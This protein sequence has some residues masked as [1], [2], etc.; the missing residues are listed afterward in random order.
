[1]E[2]IQEF[3]QNY[4]LYEIVLALGKAILVLVIGFPIRNFL[5][6]ALNRVMIK[7]EIDESLRPFLKSLFKSTLTVLILITAASFV[8][9]E[10][11]SFVAILGAAGLAI[12]LALQGTLQNFAGG[13]IILV[14]RPFKVGDYVEAA[15]QAGTVREIQ[16]FN[17]ILTTPDN[18]RITIPNGKLSNDNIKNYSA[19]ENRRVDMV[20]GIG[21]GDDIKKAKDL[22]MQMVTSDERILAD[23]A[24]QVVVAELADSS[25]NFKVRPWVANADYWNVYFDFHEKVKKEFD[26]AGISIPFPQRDVHLFQETV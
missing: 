6:R 13:V 12:G 16:I 26:A 14:L 11:T 8:G 23:P 1:M 7:R 17:T 5:S 10:T 21:Y 24:P 9:I 20:F 19:E 22:L 2:Q 25:I 3:F 18:V 4:G 15:G